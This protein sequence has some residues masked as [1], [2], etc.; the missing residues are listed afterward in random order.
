MTTEAT[1]YLAFVERLEAHATDGADRVEPRRWE[2]GTTRLH[3]SCAV[4]AY[5]AI[6]PLLHKC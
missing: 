6:V 5:T 1:A 2:A 3:R 4:V